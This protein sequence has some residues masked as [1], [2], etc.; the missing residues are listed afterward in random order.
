MNNEHSD[1]QV[2]GLSAADDECA[3]RDP[4][5]LSLLFRSLADPTRLAVLRHLGLGEHRVVDLKN[6]LGLAQSTT[7]AHLLCLRDCGLISVRTVGRA[8]VYSLAVGEELRA[9]LSS[10]ERLLAVTGDAV[11]LCPTNEPLQ[12]GSTGPTA[13][14]DPSQDAMGQDN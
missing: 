6:H 10:A 1:A 3:E 12:S 8:S 13:G 2:I 9:L 14:P 5:A 11:G 7:S 4:A